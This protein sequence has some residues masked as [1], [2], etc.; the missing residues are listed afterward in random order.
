MGSHGKICSEEHG[1]YSS[2]VDRA[3][4]GASMTTYSVED[5]MGKN[6][7]MRLCDPFIGLINI[8][9]ES[10]YFSRNS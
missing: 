3:K 4:K 10:L 9:Y 8:K 2:T 7:S 5:F 6:N 1:I